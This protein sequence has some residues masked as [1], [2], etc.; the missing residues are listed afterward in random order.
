MPLNYAGVKDLGLG[1]G[2][3]GQHRRVGLMLNK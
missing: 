2:V 3:S 1:V